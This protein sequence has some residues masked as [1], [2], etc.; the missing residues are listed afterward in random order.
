MLQAGQVACRQQEQLLSVGELQESFKQGELEVH[1]QGLWSEEA[2]Q[3]QNGE[4]WVFMKC[5]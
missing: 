1:S 5:T 4:F 3:E 2:E